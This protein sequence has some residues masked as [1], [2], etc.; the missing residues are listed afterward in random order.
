MNKGLAPSH[1]SETFQFSLRANAPYEAA[2]QENC[3]ETSYRWF[4]FLWG[5]LLMENTLQATGCTS[6]P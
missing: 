3:L 2:A 5:K 4:V 1:N 6:A